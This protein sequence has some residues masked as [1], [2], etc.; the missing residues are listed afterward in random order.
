MSGP[1][2]RLLHP[3]A[4]LAGAQGAAAVLHL[5]RFAGVGGGGYRA[6]GKTLV[7][8]ATEPREGWVLPHL[9]GGSL[10]CY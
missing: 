4:P 7:V 5:G 9:V 2:V 10:G 1:G 3:R 6:I 8:V